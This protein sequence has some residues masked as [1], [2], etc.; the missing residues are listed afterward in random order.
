MVL[1]VL[2]LV[3]FVAVVAVL[4]LVSGFDPGGAATWIMAIFLLG[5]LVIDLMYFALQ[6]MLGAGQ[7]LGKRLVGLRVINRDGG[8]AAAWPLLLRNLVRTLD[9]I[10]G[11]PLMFF[12]RHSRRVGDRLAGTVVVHDRATRGLVVLD[13]LPAGWRGAE[14]AAVEGLLERADQLDPQLADELASQLL[15]WIDRDDPG[16]LQ[17]IAGTQIRPIEALGVVFTQPATVGETA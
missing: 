1:M 4:S 10:I 13:R 11:A 8:R 2:F 6:E 12:D 17:P 16:F 14:V 15:S 3:Y 9:L 7:T 5:L